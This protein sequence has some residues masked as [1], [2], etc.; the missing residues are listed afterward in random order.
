MKYL[1]LKKLVLTSSIIALSTFGATDPSDLKLKVYKVAVSTSV[2][3]TNPVTVF[4]ESSP[5]YTDFL[6]SPTLGSGTI[7]DG[8]YPCVM[9]EFSDNLKFTPTA[10][11]GDDCVAGTE[12]TLDVCG[13]S[14]GGSGQLVDGTAF[15]CDDTD[16][17]V[18]M[19]IS[20]TSTDTSN[21][22]NAFTPPTTTNDGDR[23]INLGSAL[24]ID[25][26]SSAK[27]VVNASGNVSDSGSTCEMAPPLFSFSKL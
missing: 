1:D 12:Y 27:F 5:S 17:R 7:T 11:D 25:G 19:Y 2:L 3:C 8:T 15:T 20:T 16:Q 14:Y 18:A 4:E 23:G 9:I 24:V 22:T 13:A 10:N 21:P 26:T 6:D